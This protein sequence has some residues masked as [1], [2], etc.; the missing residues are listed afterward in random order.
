MRL[1]LDTHTFLWFIASSPDLSRNA[2]E[3]LENGDNELLLSYASI[4]EMAIKV[5]LS[6]LNVPEPFETFISEQISVNDI[7]ILPLSVTQISAVVSLPF[8]HRDP[9][10]QL[11]AAQVLTED[12]SLVSK[13]LIFDQ[14]GV[15]RLW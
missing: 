9:F 8:H 5:S 6:K 15:Q 3:L 2:K 14:Y 12:I 13:D 7:R 11:L 1:L 10:D 4:W